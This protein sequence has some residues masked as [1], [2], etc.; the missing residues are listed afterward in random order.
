MNPKLPRIT[1]E[2]VLR[3][4]KRAGFVE[5]RQRGSHLHLK[6]VSDNTRVTIPMHRGRTIPP[7][8]LRG[9]IRDA[10]LTIEEFVDLL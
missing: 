8:T 9:I 3:A 6:R 10:G 5:W 2:K 7:G 4:L 1:G